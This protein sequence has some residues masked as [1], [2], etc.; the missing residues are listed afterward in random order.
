VHLDPGATQHVQIKIPNRS[1]SV[2]DSEGNRKI[3]PGELSVWVG[4]GQPLHMPMTAGISG[5]V[6]ITGGASLPK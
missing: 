2:V 5:S 3:L 6:T 1:L 4:G